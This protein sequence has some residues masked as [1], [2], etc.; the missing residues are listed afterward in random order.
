MLGGTRDV[1]TTTGST[2]SGPGG[3]VR[4]GRRWTSRDQA[5]AS[6][7][8]PAS[9]SHDRV[10]RRRRGLA[11]S[12]GRPGLA[13]G[14]GVVESW[15]AISRCVAVVATGVA[16]RASAGKGRRVGSTQRA[17]AV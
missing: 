4:S 2:R 15:R 11:I 9:R 8:P 17:T 3:H 14:S 6:N 7:G 12:D 13:I 5:V 16:Q 1:M 10:S